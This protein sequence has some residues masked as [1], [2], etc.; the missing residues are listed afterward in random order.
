MATRKIL[1][2]SQ[3]YPYPPDGGGKIKTLATL[4]ALAQEYEIFAVFVSET[5]PTAEELYELEKLGIK[6]KVFCTDKILASVKDDLANLAWHFIRGVPHYVFQYTHQPTFPYIQSLIKEFKPDVIHVD[7][8]NMAQY[9]PKQK[10]QTWILEH[11]NVETYLYWTR[12]WQS[13]RIT[14]K[15]YLFIEMLLTFLFEW[16]TLRRFDHVFAIS[17]VERRR[18]THIFYVS[19]VTSQPLVYPATN[20]KHVPSRRP[21]I[22]F[23]GNLGWPPNEDAVEWF[24]K[25]IFPQ[26]VQKLPETE[27]HVVGK[28]QPRYEK[29]W[30]KLKNCILHGYQSSLDPFLSKADVFV[31][32][33]RMGGGMR[34]KALTALSAG[35]PIVSTPL[36]V[37]GFGLT[38][39][40]NYLRAKDADRFALMITGLFDNKRQRNRLVT[41]GFN[42][43]QKYHSVEKNKDFLAVY[44]SVVNFH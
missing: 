10:K 19:N 42:Y 13:P 43:L 18:L 24:L 31:M 25:T 6:V 36:G 26:V 22:L 17:D 37:D 20:L 11:H 28:R 44:R 32:P 7:H 29:N 16:K 27:F 4:R 5:N 38:H 23:I 12:F 8:L 35:I 9:L 15:A 1:Y 3:M 33:F 30:P 2:L 40:K 14:R 21:Y 39:G 41:A 34:I